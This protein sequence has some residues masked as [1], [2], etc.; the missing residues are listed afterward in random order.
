MVLSHEVSN[1]IFVCI[2]YL[3][4]DWILLH[5]FHRWV[6]RPVIINLFK[7]VEWVKSLSLQLRTSF[8]FSWTCIMKEKYEA[9]NFNSKLYG[10]N[11]MWY[12]KWQVIMLTDWTHTSSKQW[13]P[14]PNRLKIT[15]GRREYTPLPTSPTFPVMFLWCNYLCWVD[16]ACC[17]SYL[18]S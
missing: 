12:P 10:S 5:V 6:N 15:G 4:L 2:S 7:T 11:S 1:S 3:S 16:I 8:V 18:S 14:M 17:P 13:V 9:F